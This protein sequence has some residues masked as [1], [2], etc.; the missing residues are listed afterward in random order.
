[1]KANADA[2]KARIDF[3]SWDTEG[4]E[5]VKTNL[6]RA[7]VTPSVRRGDAWTAA[8]TLP[9]EV[10]TQAKGATEYSVALAAGTALSW[11]VRPADDALRTSFG[12][13]GDRKTAPDALE[14]RF[15]FDSRAAC[16]TALSSRWEEDV[17][18]H[19]PA[20]L[21]APD[22]GG[23][24]LSCVSGRGVTAR[25]EGDREKH[26]VDLIVELP[27]PAEKETIELEL[28]AAP[29]PAPGGLKDT[30]MWP[31]ARRGWL[32]TFQATSRWGDPDKPRS[33]PAG[34]LGNNVV[35][36]PGSCSIHFY[37]D[38]TLFVPEVAPGVSVAAMNRRT[39]EFWLDRRTRPTG[40]VICYW[41]YGGFLDANAG[42]LISSWLY[43][44][45][46]NDRK[47][48]AG[49]IEK[50]EFI[51]D[52]LATR[53]VDGDG[54]VEATQSGNANTLIEP[55]RSCA[56]FDAVNCGH[57]DGYTNAHIYRAWR[58]L[59][60]LEGLLGRTEKRDRYA[61]LA[62]RLR[63]VYAP[64]LYNE[65]TGWL[66]W[67]KSADGNLHDHAA[68]IVNALAVEYGLVPAD[69]GRDIL[70]RLREKAEQA[71]FTRWDLGVPPVLQPIPKADYLQ[72]MTGCG[73]PQRDDGSDTF[74]QYQ[75][76]G[77]AA[78]HSFHWLMAHYLVGE[79]EHAEM[80]LK[81]MLERQNT[82]GFQNGAVNEYGK[83]IDWVTWDGRPCGYE[84]LLAENN[85]FLLAVLL[86]EPAFRARYYR[87]LGETP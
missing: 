65:K 86:R 15:P 87:P 49:R 54:F 67:W 4:G 2:T 71:G 80:V 57:K 37:A 25:L 52:F 44:E 83:A 18:L 7:G 26:T 47:W 51:A 64:T 78:V 14:L 56:W 84:G 20:V 45:A 10:K 81:A 60:E 13:A 46:T 38:M 55:K 32:N 24:V 28:R 22:F 59:A 8:D 3:L 75:N 72:G 82:V 27:V 74:G 17:R 29:L 42:P 48:L 76:G 34:L 12:I 33:S 77:I 43:V 61:A 19:L 35:S 16:T 53:D 39:I 66:A 5:R 9:T 70:R 62:D 41:D 85:L 50:L 23:A 69:R 40:E 21:S 31:L 30:A 6:L 1:M 11:T 73:V 79:T 68:T 36:D 58:C 63:T